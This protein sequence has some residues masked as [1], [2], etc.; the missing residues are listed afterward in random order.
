MALGSGYITYTQDSGLTAA[1]KCTAN[2]ATENSQTLSQFPPAF[3]FWAY[4][5]KNLR[6]VYGVVSATGR[7]YKMVVCD[8]S[9]YNGMAIG[10]ATFQNKAGQT[11]IVTSKI[12]ERIIPRY[13]A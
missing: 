8:P 1:I 10:T 9:Q 12:G 3:V 13:A 6:H 2:T 5:G 7:H 11:C 4:G